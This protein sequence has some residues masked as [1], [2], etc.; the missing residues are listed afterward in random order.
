M[1]LSADRIIKNQRILFNLGQQWIKLSKSKSATKTQLDK[2]KLTIEIFSKIAI[3]VGAQGQ[4]LTSM[5]KTVIHD[6]RMMKFE[7]TVIKMKKM[8][9]RD[10]EEGNW[11]KAYDTVIQ[12]RKN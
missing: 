6:E 10:V 4:Y 1:Q 2:L 11:E 5:N 12:N 8:H 7:Q 3:N 9:P